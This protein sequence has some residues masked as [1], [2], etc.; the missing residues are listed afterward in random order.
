VFVEQD[1]GFECG[2]LAN[3][4]C[5]DSSIFLRVCGDE[6]ERIGGQVVGLAALV[7]ELLY[8]RDKRTQASLA[9]NEFCGSFVDIERTIGS[10][11]SRGR[12]DQRYPKR[13]VQLR[14]VDFSRS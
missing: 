4:H 7:A 2:I 14:S 10:P 9:D 8:F 5:G 13:T 12:T 3:E 6:I 1:A 11:A